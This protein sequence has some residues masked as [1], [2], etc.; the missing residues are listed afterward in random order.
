MAGL[1]FGL[2][3]AYACPAIPL[4]RQE[5]IAIPCRFRPIM[6]IA[7][8]CALCFQ[9][10]YERP[11]NRIKGYFIDGFYDCPAYYHGNYGNWRQNARKSKGHKNHIINY[12]SGDC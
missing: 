3:T 5:L 10:I 4:K 7:P 8:R 11:C 12:L 9:L 2:F 1:G 6:A